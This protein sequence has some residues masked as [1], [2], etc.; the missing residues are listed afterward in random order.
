MLN[1]I[2]IEKGPAKHS[3]RPFFLGV[4]STIAI[5]DLGAAK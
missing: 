5:L 2:P 3:D 4:A 1:S